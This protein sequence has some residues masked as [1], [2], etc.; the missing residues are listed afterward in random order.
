MQTKMIH[1][2]LF[3][4]KL[5]PGKGQFKCT[6]EDLFVSYEAMGNTLLVLKYKGS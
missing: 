2:L 4:R 3:S 5:F 6:R 1:I